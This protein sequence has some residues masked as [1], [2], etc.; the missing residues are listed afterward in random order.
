VTLRLRLSLLLSVLL[1][2]GLGLFGGLAY[3]LFIRQQQAQL[4]DLLQRDL[5]RLELLTQEVEVGARLVGG[6][7]GALVVQMVS[8]AGQVV[9]PFGAG[10][11][12]PLATEPTSVSLG[13][14]PLLVAS[15]P[16]NSPGGAALGTIR[17]GLAL[18]E[19]LLVRQELLR[20]LLLS[21][22]IIALLALLLGL[23]LLQ[24]ALYPLASLATQAR[25]VDPVRPQLAS[26]QGPDDEV[27]S[28]AHALNT[29]LE[30]IRSRQEA[31]RAALAEIAHELAAP[32]TLVAAHLD[33]LLA[34]RPDDVGV[35][36]AHN[37]AIELLYTSQDLLTLA[38]GELE[39][40]LNWEVVDLVAVM[41]RV[42]RE[43]PG[44]TVAV[45][46]TAPVAGDVQRLTQLVRNLVRN[47]VQA[48]GDPAAVTMRLDAAGETVRLAV[49]DGGPGIAERDLPRLFERFYSSGQGAG[50]GLYVAEQ[51][52]L[53]HGGRIEVV[54]AL[55]QGSTFTLVLPTLESQL[56]SN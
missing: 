33:R 5:Q 42:A 38:R 54:S 46:A 53:R 24:R 40:N 31:E 4:E 14:Q 10:E 52:A 11:V 16:W 17:V 7:Q 48:A 49:V 43:Y 19:A 23:G 47:A 56:E 12:L 50:V 13:G 51:L 44:V 35:S 8:T 20:A 25:A 32:L 55:G 6:N 21:G 36:A 3:L 28:V 37:A 34:Q 39:L 9:L 30:G 18:D 41:Q 22:A 1:L 26:Y 27:A 2:V 45:A 29:A 15:V